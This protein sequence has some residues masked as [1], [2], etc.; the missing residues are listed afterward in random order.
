V[1]EVRGSS[2]KATMRSVTRTLKSGLYE[3][4]SL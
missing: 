2:K 3:Q 1:Y 4:I